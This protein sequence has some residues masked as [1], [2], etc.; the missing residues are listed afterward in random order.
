MKGGGRGGGA[1]GGGEGG[2]A[3]GGARRGR[4]N[5]E[6]ERRITNPVVKVCKARRKGERLSEQAWKWRREGRRR[7]EGRVF[8]EERCARNGMRG[9]GTRFEGWKSFREDEQDEQ[10]ETEETEETKA[11]GEE[12]E[13][14][15]RRER[16]ITWLL[17]EGLHCEQEKLL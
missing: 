6:E 14:G 17:V 2:G 10:E 11:E 5:K 8:D 12:G 3:G 13:R 9:K 16:R 1:G 4:R 15:E 7:T